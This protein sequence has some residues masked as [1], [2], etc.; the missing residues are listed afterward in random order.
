MCVCVMII[1][2]WVSL[3]YSAFNYLELNGNVDI[4]ILGGRRVRKWLEYAPA[5][6][7]QSALKFADFSK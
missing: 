4:N 5:I 7:G 1:F 3:R 6:F 2:T